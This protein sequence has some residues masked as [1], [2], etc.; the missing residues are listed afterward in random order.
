MPNPPKEKTNPELLTS[1]MMT[2]RKKVPPIRKVNKSIFQKYIRINPNVTVNPKANPSR[3][4]TKKAKTI[5]MRMTFNNLPIKNYPKIIRK[6]IAKLTIPL[7]SLI[8]KS[9]KNPQSHTMTRKKISTIKRN[10]TLFQVK[11]LKMTWRQNQSQAPP[12]L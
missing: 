3:R 7:K 1:T 5:L 6:T 8:L 2:L 11:T 10:P 4:F 12:K 9:I